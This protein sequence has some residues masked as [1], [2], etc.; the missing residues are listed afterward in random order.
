MSEATRGTEHVRGI[1]TPKV[2]SYIPAKNL[3]RR[4]PGSLPVDFLQ[5][6]SRRLIRYLAPLERADTP[7][8]GDDPG[9]LNAG[10]L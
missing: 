3:G 10:R 6:A 7:T 5:P 2:A 4:W 8:G 1:E 9:R